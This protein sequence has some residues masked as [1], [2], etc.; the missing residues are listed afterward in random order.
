VLVAASWVGIVVDTRAPNLLA[1]LTL[2]G[3]SYGAF[4]VLLQQIVWNLLL[5]GAPEGDPSS[6]PVLVMSWA[7]IL[8]TNTIWGAFLGLLAAGMRRLAG[9]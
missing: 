4:A 9:S 8:V 6:G 5:G 3:A 1:T 7:S 2:A